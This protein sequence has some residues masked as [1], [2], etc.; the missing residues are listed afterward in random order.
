LRRPLGFWDTLRV[1]DEPKKLP[2][3]PI[4]IE[5]RDGQRIKPP[6]PMCGAV[7]WGILQ[8][9]P[10]PEN[11]DAIAQSGLVATRNDQMLALP[12]DVYA[13]GNCGFLWHVA[14]PANIVEK[15]AIDDD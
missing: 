9:L 6:C 2:R 3:S 5:T 15:D 10:D 11:K 7:S 12:I 14:K 13:C 4:V 8:P 1:A